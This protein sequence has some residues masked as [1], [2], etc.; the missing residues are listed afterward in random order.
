MS[1]G[2]GATHNIAGTPSANLFDGT[3][4]YVFFDKS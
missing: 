2:G 3:P 4:S 1:R